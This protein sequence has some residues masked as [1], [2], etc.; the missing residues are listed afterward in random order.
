MFLLK[1]LNHWAL[2]VT[3][4]CGLASSVSSSLFADGYDQSTISINMPGGSAVS[5]SPGQTQ[6]FKLSHRMFVHKLLLQVD[7]VNGNSGAEVIVNGDRKENMYL[8][9]SDPLW[10]ATI[11][12]ETSS[13]QITGT[14]AQMGRQGQFVIRDIKAVVTDT[15]YHDPIARPSH[16]ELCTSRCDH[17]RFPIYYKSVM[18]NVSNRAI[19]L[20]DRLADYANYRDYGAYLLPIKKAAAE[21]RAVAEARGDASQ[22]ARPYFYNLLKNLDCAEAYFNDT[23]ERSAAFEM[24]TE[25]LALREHI[26]DILD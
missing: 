18:G 16:P 26:R 17:L 25:L 24:A 19:V 7:S 10:V 21:A 20:T 13:I 3:L 23:F 11:E 1:R 22:Y 2:A 4:S 14:A 8:Q 12:E 6:T 5:L 9:S 15:D